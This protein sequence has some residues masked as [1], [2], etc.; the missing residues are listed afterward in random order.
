MVF[1][2]ISLRGMLMKKSFSQ[3]WVEDECPI[4]LFQIELPQ[5]NYEELNAGWASSFSMRSRNEMKSKICREDAPLS[6]LTSS[7]AEQI[8]PPNLIEWR[9]RKR[10]TVSNLISIP[11]AP[12][13][14]V[15]LMWRRRSINEKKH[16]R[17]A[18]YDSEMK[19]MME[20]EITMQCNGLWAIG[21]SS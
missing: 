9:K 7:P 17:E 15:V 4:K 6:W 2:H 5:G 11:P 3:R 14:I 12:M 16:P 13:L 21:P 19:I 10:K 8:T 18:P 1:D 20:R